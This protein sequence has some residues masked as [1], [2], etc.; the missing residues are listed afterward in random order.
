SPN[1]IE[2]N[3][4]IR[5]EYFHYEDDEPIDYGDN[6]FILKAGYLKSNFFLENFS[7]DTSTSMIFVEKELQVNLTD[8]LFTGDEDIG[9]SPTTNNAF[10]NVSLTEPDSD[11]MGIVQLFS[12]LTVKIDES[13]TNIT[14]NLIKTS[15]FPNLK[16]LIQYNFPHI[17]TD[18]FYDNGLI[19]NWIKEA[20]C[21]WC[22]F[23]LN[24]LKDDSECLAGEPSSSS[25][26]SSSEEEGVFPILPFLFALIM[27]SLFV[28]IRKLKINY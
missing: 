26:S 7:P 17:N 4:D 8:T 27:I 16:I 25:S 1:S 6:D 12:P 18:L 13:F 5:F 10:I 23:N 20:A 24:D 2:L 3:A 22:Y 15:S 28:F 11:Y 14:I 21:F 9:I 19:V